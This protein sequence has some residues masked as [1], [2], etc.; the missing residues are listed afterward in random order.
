MNKIHGQFFGVFGGMKEYFSSQ[1]SQYTLHISENELQSPDELREE[2]EVL[3][4]FVGSRVDRTVLD[5][6]P[7]LK[8]IV[9]LSTGYDHIDV[10]AATERK[11]VVCNVPTYGEN[12]VAEHA[13]ALL[14]AGM[15]SVWQ[16]VLI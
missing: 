9:T 1:L 10:V 15:L 5:R 16:K 7:N 3:G 8:L 6:L 4:V 14:L 12:T 11:I 2:T 13:M